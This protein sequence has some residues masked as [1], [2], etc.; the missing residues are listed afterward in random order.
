MFAHSLTRCPHAHSQHVIKP[1][2]P[3]ALRLQAMLLRGIVLLYN[4]QLVL[5][6]GARP[7]S[8]SQL[9]VFH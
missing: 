6:Y 9:R 1:V 7:P 5:L 8:P 2:A 4:R 3:L